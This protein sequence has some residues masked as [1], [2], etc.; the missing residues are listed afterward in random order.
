MT[1]IPTPREPTSGQTGELTGWLAGWLTDLLTGTLYFF[2]QHLTRLCCSR[3]LIHSVPHRTA[4][5]SLPNGDRHG[6]TNACLLP[7]GSRLANPCYCRNGAPTRR[8]TVHT[9]GPPGKP[10]HPIHTDAMAHDAIRCCLTGHVAR[11]AAPMSR[12][13]THA[14]LLRLLCCQ[15]PLSPAATAPAASFRTDRTTPPSACH[16][17]LALDPCL[18]RRCP[19]G[20][21]DITTITP[22]RALE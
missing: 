11:R 9:A 7:T 1:P 17:P 21:T 20:S 2:S 10:P 22:L 5:A 13:Q 8:H 12:P 19:T 14:R 4:Q 15:R 6:F 16:G 18:G 3:R